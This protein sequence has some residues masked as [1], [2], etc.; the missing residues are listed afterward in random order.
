VVREFSY[1]VDPDIR[2][3]IEKL[4]DWTPTMDACCN[5]DAATDCP[6]KCH[7]D[8]FLSVPASGHRVWLHPPPDQIRRYLQHYRREKEKNPSG[9]SA[10]VI[11][12]ST[13]GKASDWLRL[14][15]GFELVA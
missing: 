4:L 9:T 1:Y 5:T 2:R 12:P 13:K 8:S 7:Q 11:L 15:T 10:V 3:H 14:L 6:S